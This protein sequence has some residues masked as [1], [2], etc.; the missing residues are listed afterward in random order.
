MP[1]YV[2]AFFIASLLSSKGVSFSMTSVVNNTFLL[3]VNVGKVTRYID[4]KTLSLPNPSFTLFL[5]N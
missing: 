1:V 2:L 5:F 3:A 4:L